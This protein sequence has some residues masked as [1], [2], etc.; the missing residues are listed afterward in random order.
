MTNE[1]NGWQDVR[2]MDEKTLHA[3]VLGGDQEAFAE[4]MRRY[5]PVVRYKI[6]RVLG[7]LVAAETLDAQIAELWCALMADGLGHPARLG[8][9]RE[10]S[11]RGVARQRRSARQRRVVAP[12]PAR[13]GRR[14][15]R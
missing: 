13:A 14:L 15:R 7:R 12:P 5:D 10:R 3:A 1:R 9:G 8:R 4:I 6:W 11:V 2:W